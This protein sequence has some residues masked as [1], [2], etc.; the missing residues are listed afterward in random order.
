MTQGD[1]LS[2]TIFNVVVDAVAR[3]WVTMAL[4]EAEKRE[5]RG[6]EGRHQASLFYA[7]GGMVASSDP[8]WIQWAFNSLVSLFQRVGLRTSFG[9]TVSMVRKPCQAAGT[10]SEVGVRTEEYGGGDEIPGTAEGEGR[11]QGMR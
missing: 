3:H 10:K 11:V 2:P 7:D 8:C 6:E 1:P 5:E 4:D 9:K